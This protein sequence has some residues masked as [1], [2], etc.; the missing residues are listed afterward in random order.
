MGKVLFEIGGHVEIRQEVAKEGMS[1]S[2][3][4]ADYSTAPR[5]CETA[6]PH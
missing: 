2:Y 5:S 4:Y 3:S 6:N 1:P